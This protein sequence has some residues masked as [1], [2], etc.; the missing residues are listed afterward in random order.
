VFPLA[1]KYPFTIAFSGKRIGDLALGIGGLL[2]VSERF[3]MAW[4]QE[5]L[6]GLVFSSRPVEYKVKRGAAV[7]PAP[8][9]FYA[10]YPEPELVCLAPGSSAD[11]GTKSDCPVCCSSEVLGLRRVVFAAGHELPDF[12]MPSCLSGWHAISERAAALIE[13]RGFS[14][15]RFVQSFRW[16]P[17]RR[18]VRE[19]AH[20]IHAPSR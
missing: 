14:N 8:P 13:A 5:D 15:F 4:R 11:Y 10:A 16:T 20:V 3:M 7:D 12:F 2:I 1:T 6:L 19:Y 17:E 9:V 18:L